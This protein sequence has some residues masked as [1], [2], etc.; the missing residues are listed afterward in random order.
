ML[1]SLTLSAQSFYGERKNTKVSQT[2]SEAFSVTF[3]NSMYGITFQKNDRKLTE[4]LKT[5]IERF[6]KHTNH[7]KYKAIGTVSLDIVSRNNNYYIV[8]Q[9]SPEKLLEL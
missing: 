7:S 3:E 6:V 1:C 5:K 4:T 8:D 9:K 2:T